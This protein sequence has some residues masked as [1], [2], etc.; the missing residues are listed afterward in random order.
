MN[1]PITMTP[2]EFRKLAL[3]SEKEILENKD[4]INFEKELVIEEVRKAIE[5]CREELYMA[6]MV[7]ER[8]INWSLS[9]RP[10]PYIRIR[11]TDM[12][13][14]KHQVADH[15]LDAGFQVI[16]NSTG[17]TISFADEDIFYR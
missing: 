4:R 9:N 2:K 1:N 3:K 15:F 6:A 8:K 11:E 14:I 16:S 12:S 17:F 7:G 10:A 5:A 13:L